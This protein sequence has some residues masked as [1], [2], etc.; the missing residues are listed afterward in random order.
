MTHKQRVLELLSDGEPHGHME[1]YRLGVM[2]HSRVADLRRDGHEIACWRDGDDYLYQL[3][4]RPLEPSDAPH[5]PDLRGS[6]APSWAPDGSSGWGT[7]PV[8]PPVRTGRVDATADVTV[9][10][11]QAALF[12]LSPST[13]DEP[14]G[15]AA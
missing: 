10:Q 7:L 15:R 4:A 2:L 13:Y 8:L 5:E 1:G 6:A 3:V 9:G 14:E 12:D 11:A